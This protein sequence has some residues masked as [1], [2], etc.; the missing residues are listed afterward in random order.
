MKTLLKQN[1]KSSAI[2]VFLLI[3]LEEH[4]IGIIIGWIELIVQQFLWY[5]RFFDA[6]EDPLLYVLSL[7]FISFSSVI[8]LYQISHDKVYDEETGKRN[9]R[10]LILNVELLDRRL[11]DFSG[12]FG[13]F[14]AGTIYT[15][16]LTPLWFAWTLYLLICVGWV[17]LFF[18]LVSVTIFDWIGLADLFFKT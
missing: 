15:L 16:I 5:W 10:P 1:P 4:T 13:S 12:F 18:F 7:C 2:F 6:S 14:F 17:I 11:E 8:G 9:Y 3:F